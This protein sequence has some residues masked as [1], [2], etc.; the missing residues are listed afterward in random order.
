MGEK[1]GLVKVY[2]KKRG[3]GIIQAENRDYFFRWTDIIST[4][5]KE[6]KTGEQVIFIPQEHMRGLRAVNVQALG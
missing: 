4:S 2:N 1:L 6:C 3:Y 5:H